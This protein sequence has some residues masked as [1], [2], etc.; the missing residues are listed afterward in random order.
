MNIE[1]EQFVTAID[2]ENE[3]NK[4]NIE[5]KPTEQ[6]Y[7]GQTLDQYLH[8]LDYQFS[9]N[10]EISDEELIDIKHN[11]KMIEESERTGLKVNNRE[12]SMAVL[13]VFKNMETWQK[14]ML[15][16]AQSDPEN[17]KNSAHRYYGS[18][19]V[20]M[21]SCHTLFPGSNIMISSAGR[22][23]MTFGRELA[24]MVRSDNPILP[25]LEKQM[26]QLP[27]FDLMANQLHG[28]IENNPQDEVK[29]LEV[30]MYTISEGVQKDMKINLNSE[31]ENQIRICVEILYKI[32]MLIDKIKNSEAYKKQESAQKDTPQNQ[33]VDLIVKTEEKQTPE[34]IAAD[35]FIQRPNF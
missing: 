27:D 17:Q 6:K 21:T 18:K 30:I 14:N 23:M 4:K 28:N 10:A 11:L 35:E 22:E 19:K 29:R 8:D 5:F 15:S 16:M 12:A 1:N 25:N 7:N 2:F 13:N 20:F 34:E 3:Q 9:V 33:K 31:A 24:V 26:G 32:Q